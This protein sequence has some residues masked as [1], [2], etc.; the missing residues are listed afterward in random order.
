MTTMQEKFLIIEKNSKI[1]LVSQSSYDK[2][3]RKYLVSKYSENSIFEISN[4]D[5][6]FSEVIRFDGASQDSKSKYELKELWLDLIENDNVI[7]FEV[8]I[9]KA[10]NFFNITSLFGLN[11]I[12]SSFNDDFTYFKILDRNKVY[13]NS[14]SIVTR[15]EL[16]LLNK[17]EKKFLY[18]RFLKDL[19]LMKLCDWSAYEK[20]REEIIVYLSGGT[21]YSKSFLE[22]VKKAIG[23]DKFSEI[24]PHL[25]SVGFFSENFEPLYESLKLDSSY[26]YNEKDIDDLAPTQEKTNQEILDAFTID[27]K[28]S[29]DFDD[30]ISI[31]KADNTYL[32][33]VHITNFSNLFSNN[34]I[35]AKDA[36]RI[37]NTIYTPSSHFNLYDRKLV[38]L[39]SLKANSVRPVLSIKFEL[40]GLDIVSCKIEKNIIKVSKNFTYEKFESLIEKSTDYAFLNN[41]TENLKIERLKEA[42][43]KFF[44]QEINIKFNKEKML[45]VNQVKDLKS[46]RIISELMIIANLYCSRYFIANGLPGIFR[47]QKKSNN[48]ET[49]IIDEDPPFCFHRKV[50]PVDVSTRPEPHN[51]LGI[52]SY[53]QITS[54]IR[55]FFDSIN[56]WQISYFITE[57]KA[58]YDEKEIQKILTTMLPQVATV[59]EKSK[60]VFKL[61]ILRYLEQIRAQNIS[62]YV[63]ASLKDKYI[64]FFNELNFFESIAKEKCRNLYEK[65]DFIEL[66]F[67]F[68]D[69][70]NLELVNLKD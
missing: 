66:S 44:N 1:Y 65:D 11:S 17:K 36:K 55:R 6:I 7:N 58:L 51:G 67:D 54:P 14:E 63:Y 9:K 25:K 42:D 64:I 10:I 38:D 8:F 24:V 3:R 48:L 53:M 32:L 52:E 20:Q 26:S 19:S 45:V 47:S 21:K 70:Q 23:I 18:D 4:K 41:F 28:G 34:S 2:K 12:T 57:G 16:S 40:K 13:L 15:I 33:Y 49:S 27:D 35:Y 5:I 30:A 31:K 61:W 50:S 22:S 68:V 59:R 29:Y 56:M 46:R 60:K 39:M 69:I 62:G 43:F 37:I